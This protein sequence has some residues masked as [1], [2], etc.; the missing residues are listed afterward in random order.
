MAWIRFSGVRGKGWL[1]MVTLPMELLVAFWQSAKAIFAHRPDAV[2]GMGGYVSFPGG[3]MA[4]FLNRPLAVHEQNAIPGL[5]NRILSRL[6]DRVLSGFPGAFG[7]AA[8]VIWT[9]NP[10]RQDI[11]ALPAPEERYGARAGALRVLV[12]G[13]SQGAQVL[14][15]VVPE[16]L[17]LLPAAT[18]PVV[19]HQAG[20][21]HQP[22]VAER[23]RSHGVEAHVVAFIDDM[24]QRYAD[25]DLIICRAGASTI[26][27]LAAAGIASVL[28]PFPHAVDDHQSANAR[29]LAGRGA[30]LLI[31]Q[32]EFTA[33]RLS[34]LLAGCT[35]GELLAMAQN[36]R[37]AAKPEATREV[38][39]IC[40]ALAKAA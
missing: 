27:E 10:V 3:M 39:E 23:Y 22:G 9:G 28:V 12:V 15:T 4:S 20:Q 26:A 6:A 33:Q 21:A 29:F 31:P 7:S 34:Q 13:G 16:A 8:A 40:L 38:A 25:T 14:N 18:R 2:L 35:R 32:R 36:A 1:R 24:A 5:A 30:A 19:T 17:A 11:A 37:A